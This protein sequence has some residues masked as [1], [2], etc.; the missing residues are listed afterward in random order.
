MKKISIILGIILTL[1]LNSCVLKT[2]PEND[3]NF[4]N[5]KDIKQLDG[6]YQNLADGQIH[7]KRLSKYL[8]ENEKIEHHNI[9]TVCVKTLDSNTIE[10]K[11]KNYKK[12]LHIKK[13]IKDKD[14]S[15]K[16]GKITF[17]KPTGINMDGIAAIAFEYLP[18]GLDQRG[19]GKI[20]NGGIGTGIALL[21]PFVIIG[22]DSYRFLKIN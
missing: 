7:S 21:I 8:W 1:V 20:T 4:S 17:N 19:D 11:A 9:T 2:G 5:I 18:I 12:T 14:F 13:F 3:V 6:C 15:L 16:S 10:V 22:E